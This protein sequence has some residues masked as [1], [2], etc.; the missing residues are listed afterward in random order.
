MAT[1]GTS[2]LPHWSEEMANDG[3]PTDG[4]WRELA[5]QIQEENDPEK[6]IDLVQELIASFDK[7]RARKNSPLMRKPEKPA[8]SAGV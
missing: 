1:E 8:D 7:E 4:N 5:R 3:V 2:P 6:M